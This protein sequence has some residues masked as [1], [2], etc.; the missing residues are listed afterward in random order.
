MAVILAID[1]GN[2][3]IKWSLYSKGISLFEGYVLQGKRDLLEKSLLALPDSDFIIISNVAG[4]PAETLLTPLFS[5]WISKPH[6]VTSVA[7]QCGVRN[8][9]LEP[10]QLGSDRWASLIGVRHK[11]PKA[12]VVVNVGTATTVDILSSSGSFLGGIIIPGTNLMLNALQTGTAIACKDRGSYV[13]F[14]LCTA[15]AIQTGIISS[16]VG[17]IERLYHLHRSN[18]THSDLVCIITGGALAS[19][20]PHFT[21]PVIIEESLV[22]DGLLVIANEIISEAS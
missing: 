17:A 22:L 9:Y 1:S 16:I 6:W 7:V 8:H 10:R 15:D 14:P 4:S 18:L 3:R 12:C 13:D 2:T 21:I 20:I 5:N 11:Y 19:L